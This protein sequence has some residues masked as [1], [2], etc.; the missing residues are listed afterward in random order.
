MVMISSLLLL[1]V[2]SGLAQDSLVSSENETAPMSLQGIW[3][4]SLG[5]G[6]VVMAVNQSGDTLSGQA[7]FEGEE[8]WN[9]V[10]SGSLSGRAVQIAMAALQGKVLVSTLMSGMA[11]DESIEGG[12]ARYDSNG[13]ASKGEFAAAMI[14]PDTADYTPAEI[15]AAPEIATTP[16]IAVAPEIAPA[17]AEQVAQ[18]EIEPEPAVRAKSKYFNDV[19][20]LAKGIDPNI[21]PRSAP[22]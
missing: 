7:K 14:N 9:G 16:E 15:A 3:M 19:R 10:I 8:P 5:D 22:L 6:E 18:P 13:D 17:P 12:Y 11:Q 1:S 20:E 2:L 4:I 21:M